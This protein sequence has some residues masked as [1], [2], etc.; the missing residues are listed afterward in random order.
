M[1]AIVLNEYGDSSHLK[2]A[3]IAEPKPGSGEIKV[4]VAAAG[5]NPIDWKLRSGDYQALMPIQF[6]FAQRLA[7][8]GGISRV[9]LKV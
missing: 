8:A 7:E 9:L 5:L 6:P 4:K 3:E 2:L 1:K